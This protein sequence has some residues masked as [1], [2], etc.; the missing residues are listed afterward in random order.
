MI[1]QK[2]Q[3]AI[4]HTSCILGLSVPLSQSVLSKDTLARVKARSFLTIQIDI[5][6]SGI[7]EV[8]TIDGIA[9]NKESLESLEKRAARVVRACEDLGVVVSWILRE[10]EGSS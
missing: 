10:L 3:S 7:V 6:L 5:L 9:L 2:R 4:Q 1:S 8:Q